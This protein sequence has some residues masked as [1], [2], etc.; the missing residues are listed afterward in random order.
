[1]KHHTSENIQFDLIE[2]GIDFV[3]SGVE[4]ILKD[5]SPYLLKYAVLH[6]SAGTELLLKEALKNE[7]WSLIFESPNNAKYELLKSGEFKSVDFETLLTRLTNICEIELSEKETSILRQLKKLRNKIE[8]FEFNENQKAIK[9]LSSKVL[10]LLL[11]F[12]NENFNQQTLSD[13]SKEGIERLRSIA[14]GFKEFTVLRNSQIKNQISEAQ[15]E[16]KIENCPLCRQATLI[17]NE[18]LICLF[19]GFSDSPESVARLY[20]ENIL[21]ESYYMCFKDGGEFPVTDCIH[22]ESTDTF[23][24]KGVDGYVCFSCFETNQSSELNSC[25]NCGQLFE[26]RSDEIDICEYCIE[27]LINKD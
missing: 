15:K 1:M 10:C 7:H 12:I 21:G 20:A 17:L 8:H 6:L 25:N 24:D 5:K 14:T 3:T 13:S 18:D 22:C 9:S 2:N 27:Y 26:K 4:H 19:C 16:H 11:N 23:V